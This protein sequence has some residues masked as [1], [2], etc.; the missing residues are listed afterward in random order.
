MENM[1]EIDCKPEEEEAKA[2]KVSSGRVAPPPGLLP[3][4]IRAHGLLEA[5]DAEGFAQLLFHLG[6]LG[7]CAAI[8]SWAY[9][10]GYWGL[11]LLAEIPFAVAES[12]LFN[13]FHEMVHNTAF[14]TQ[15]LNTVLAHPLG[16][17]IFRGAKWFWCFHWTHHR[18]TNDPAKD[19]ELSGESVDL[20]DP[21]KTAVGY[22]Q[23]LSGYPFGFERVG[24][25]WNMATGAE[26]DPWVADKPKATQ[27][28]VRW[29]SA[30]YLTGYA[31]LAVLS[32]I[33]PERVGLKLFLFWLLP[34]CLG[35][36]HLRMYQF[37]EHRACTMGPYTE[38]NAWICARTSTTWWLYRKL[39]WQMPYHV[40]HHAYPNVPFHKLQATH[41]LV[42]SYYTKQGLKAAPSGC[43][44]TG[45]DGYLGL[46]KVMFHR[47]LGNVAVA[48]AAKAA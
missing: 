18:Y 3:K 45:E 43:N 34:H 19:P 15:S 33:F 4:D 46:H 6:F 21:T 1:A 47:M 16:F 7:L 11:L 10:H 8:V 27:R 13:G 32:L 28:A 31:V 9:E 2:A 39:A 44:P 30:A 24:R 20:D 25:M 12:F 29:E 35:A 37:A 36:G 17:L 22:A 38:T 26:I 40:E 23:F 48:K 14:A 5:S 41:E 42:K